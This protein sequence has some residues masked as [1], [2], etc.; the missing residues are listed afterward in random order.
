MT[1]AVRPCGF[2][3][4]LAGL[5]V[6]AARGQPP[7]GVAAWKL[8][9]LVL[10]NGA[11]FDGLVLSDTPDRVRLQVVRRPPG[12]PSY[13]YTDTFPRSEI[14]RVFR[15]TDAERDVL[16]ERLAELDPNGEGEQRRMDALELQDADWLGRPRGARRYDGEQFTLTSSAPEEVTRRA[17]VRLEQVYA[18]FARFLPPT[19]PEGK[20]TVV[21]LAPDAAEY[22]ALLGPAGVPFL[23]H[24]AVY[25]PAAN[26]IV[27]GHDLRKSGADL[28]AA[29][30]ENRKQLD[31][32]DR[33]EQ[34]VRKL[35]RGAKAD[36]DRHLAVAARERQK[37]KAA[38]EANA[39]TFD[40]VT[41]RLFA[42]LYHEAFH[43]YASTFV[44][45]P[46]PA[47]AVAAGRGTGELPRW[48]NEGLA[49][50][51]ESAVV[52]AG[53]LRADH[54]DPDRLDRAKKRLAAKEPGAGLVPL[55]D[56]LTA[57]K[58][59]F[60]AAHADQAAAADRAYLSGWALAHYLTFDRRLI[61]TKAFEKYLA[62]VNTGADPR[63]ALAGPAGPAVAAL[64]RGRP[65]DLGR[66]GAGGSV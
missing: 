20:P 66:G 16:K 59:Q 5:L 29:R 46:L 19:R 65:G 28:Q 41:A 2:L 14:A 40:K 32:V 62:A 43:A 60:R 54:P 11:T 51:F 9:R 58:D 50:V 38:D 57:G 23:R 25:D 36:L 26:R 31:E 37:V 12:R 45:P 17:A 3:A 33:Y 18:A 8:D 24:P 53:E 47:D 35:Y 15:I 34:R 48:L 21:L 39:A 49:Q 56:L 27:C 63:A 13:T 1:S 64:A 42:I 30:A 44:Y 10:A 6:G 22:A 7:A 4:L 61:G 55:A 52:E